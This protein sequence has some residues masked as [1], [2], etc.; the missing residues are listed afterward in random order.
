MLNPFITAYEMCHARYL[1]CFI[2]A[3]NSTRDWLWMWQRSF[4]V[5]SWPCWALYGCVCFWKCWCIGCDACFAANE[6]PACMLI[7]LSSPRWLAHCAQRLWGQRTDLNCPGECLEALAVASLL[8]HCPE[9]CDGDVSHSGTR[10][11]RHELV[12]MHASLLHVPVYKGVLWSV[13]TA[14]INHRPYRLS[15]YCI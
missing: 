1:T 10:A 15:A 2:C 14:P 8:T 13:P 11:W 3:T 12:T 7:C 9:Q 4:T 5:T 6:V